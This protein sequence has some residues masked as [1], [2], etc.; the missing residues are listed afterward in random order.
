MMLLDE[1]KL[2]SNKLLKSN[3]G[4]KKVIKLLSDGES[5]QS[6][7]SSLTQI[8]SLIGK[9]KKKNKQILALIKCALKRD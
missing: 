3:R 8:D 1:Q 9:F 6:L 5:E 7:E 4:D 2:I